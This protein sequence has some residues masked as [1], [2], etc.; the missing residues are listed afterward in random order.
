MWCL[1][2]HK[3]LEKYISSYLSWKIAVNNILRSCVALVSSIFPNA[4][5]LFSNIFL[6]GWSILVERI[7]EKERSWN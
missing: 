5:V 6:G 2:A 4:T 7:L 1:L 3:S